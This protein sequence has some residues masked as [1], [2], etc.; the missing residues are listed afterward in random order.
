MKGSSNEGNGYYHAC[1][2]GY[3]IVRISAMSVLL[4]QA[5]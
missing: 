3:R 5:L 1:I 2:N 4:G